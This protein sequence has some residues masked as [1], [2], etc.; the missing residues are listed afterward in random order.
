MKRQAAVGIRLHRLWFGQKTENRGM[1]LWAKVVLI[2]TLTLFVSIFM[3][4]GWSGPDLAQ[5]DTAGPRSPSAAS[6]TNWGTATNVYTSNAA[7]ATFAGNT[8][9]YLQITGY[10]FTVPAGSTIN[11]VQVSVTGFNSNATATNRQIRVGLT[12][13]GTALTGTEKTAQTLP[14]ANGTIVLGSTSDPWGATLTQANV[15]A[16]TF[17]VLI[18]DND[19]NIGGTFN[20]DYVSVT[21][22]Y[23]LP[24]DTTAPAITTFTVPTASTSLT[25]SGIAL[26]A[27]DAVG[28]TGYLIN[29]SA[30]TPAPAA[31]NLATAPTSYTAGSSGAKTLYAWARDAAG[32]VS[33]SSS[34]TCTITLPG[35]GNPL[36][37]NSAILGNKYGIWGVDGG[38]YGQFVCTTCHNKTTNN[39]KRGADTITA[40]LGNWSSS[41]TAG[42]PVVFNNM[43]AFGNDAG[44]HTTSTRICE[45]CHSN[46]T[47]HRYN[48]TGQADLNHK[49]ANQTDC[50][51]CHSHADAFKGKGCTACHGSTAASSNPIVTGKHTAHI[52]NAVYGC[53]D[54]HAKSVTDSVTIKSAPTAHQNSIYGDF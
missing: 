9:N 48:T 35:E 46:T 40:P 13:N 2:S 49:S 3:N 53:A 11:G 25:I 26:A 1:N 24:P 4:Q 42:V 37:H 27:S 6:G 30:A 50:T 51:T 12:L 18:R 29:E 17:G 19:I 5:A 54:C 45:V 23:T 21:I 36:I 14:T 43:T 41:K 10:G 16:S 15:N 34:R 8:Q 32:N 52:A 22:T 38:E 7:Y 28:V 33:V 44:G 47:V 31:V 39:V 20:I